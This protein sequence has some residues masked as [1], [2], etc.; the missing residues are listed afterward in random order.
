MRKKLYAACAAVLLLAVLG[1]T[2]QTARPAFEYRVEYHGTL[3]EKKLNELGSQG[4]ELVA[5]ETTIKNGDSVVHGFYFKR[6]K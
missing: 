1:F 6:A 5:T 2:R 4:W 3:S